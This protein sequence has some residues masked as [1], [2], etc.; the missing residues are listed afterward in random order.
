M[1]SNFGRGSK[2]GKKRS[3]YLNPTKHPQTIARNAVPT[4][5]AGAAGSL[6]PDFRD[7]I[8][9]DVISGGQRGLA[10]TQAYVGGQQNLLRSRYGY[11][12]DNFT[13][14]PSNPYGQAQLLKR[15]FDQSRAGTENNYAARG[16]QTTGA[17]GRMQA[18]NLNDYGQRNNAL[19]LQFLADN[20]ALLNQLTQAQDDYST[21]I[22]P[23]A[24]SDALGRAIQRGDGAV[25]ANADPIV[26]TYFDAKGNKVNVH[27]SGRKATIKKGK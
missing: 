13:V 3:Q 15:A 26:R 1:A 18:E 8:Y 27:Q 14:D 16:Q 25:P 21:R 6:T 10:N 9:N 5:G 23:G 11:L 17:Y 22:V 19:Q 7:S 4:V 20:A 24:A 12:D 2:P